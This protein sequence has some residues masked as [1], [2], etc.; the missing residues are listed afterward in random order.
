M[1]KDEQLKANLIIAK[2]L[3]YILEDSEHGNT[4]YIQT[5]GDKFVGHRAFNIFTNPSDCQAAVIHLGEKH[6]LF[7]RK[8]GV[9]WTCKTGIVGEYDTYPTYQEAV[10]AAYL[11]LE[12]FYL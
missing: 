11:A 7:P 1:T 8:Y 9:G 10:S 5:G 6:D 12:S 2:A 4:C 3:G